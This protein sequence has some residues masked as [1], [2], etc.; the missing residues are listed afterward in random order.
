MLPRSCDGD[1]TPGS[2][3]SQ[4]R[5]QVTVSSAGEFGLVARIARRLGAPPPPA[6]PGDDAAV[7]PAPSGAV[8]ATTDLLVERRHFRLEWSTP[9]DVGR[10]AAAQ[11]L[12][13][14]VAMGAVPTALLVGLGCPP[15]TPLAVADGVADGVRDEC[16]LVGASRVGGDVVAADALILAVTALGDLQ[17]WPPVTRAGAGP[18]DLVVLAGTVG[19]A[20]A[21]LALLSAGVRE[22]PLVDA[23]RRPAPPYDRGPALAR[24][25]ATAMIDVS[26][27]LLADLGH[28]ARASAVGI[29]VD[30]DALAAAVPGVPREHLLAGGEDHGLAATVPPA[31]ALP[32]G[33]VVIGR[34]VPGDGQVRVRGDAPPL[35]TLGYDH[36]TR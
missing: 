33:V 14:V 19:R 27:G 18:G 25:G 12:A 16:A 6:G 21:G 5:G 20:A 3:R 28:L 2:R 9:N 15:S 23:H 26:D 34:V 7:V 13:D 4:Q 1:V 35:T 29:E 36:F 32:P 10:K 17:G 8:V 30:V 31:V 24:A 22:G 11:N